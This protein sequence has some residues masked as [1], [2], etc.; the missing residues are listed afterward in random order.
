MR[1]FL[2]FI[3]IAWLAQGAA[4]TVS[5]F[6]DGYI[7]EVKRPSLRS[8]G[9]GLLLEKSPLSKV[10]KGLKNKALVWVEREKNIFFLKSL[11]TKCRKAAERILW[12]VLFFNAKPYC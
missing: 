9:E 8:Y 10:G 6:L 12:W 3:M 11:V 4:N 2:L 7:E 1:L 5:L